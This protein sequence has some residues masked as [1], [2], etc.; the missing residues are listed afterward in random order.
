MA[1]AKATEQVDFIW[2]GKDKNGMRTKGEIAAKSETVA[3]SDL[4]QMGIRVISIKKKP[5]PLFGVKV[6]KITP[7]DIAIFSRQLATMLEAGVPLVQSFDIIGKGHENASMQHLLLSIKADIEGGS[8]LAE[9]LKKNPVYFDELFCNLVE[10]GEHAGVLET[11]LDKIATYKEKTES[12]KKKIKKALTYPIAVLVVAFVVTAILLIFVVPVFEEL[13]QGFGADLP[14]F[15]RMVIDLSEWMQ[16]WWWVIVA[17]VFGC[18]YTFGY[19]KKRSRKFNHALDRTLLKIPVVG[20]ILNKSAVARF[21]RTLSTMSAAGVPL[22]E[23]LES[24]AGSCGNIIYADAVLKMREEVSTGQR[25]QYAM[26][27]TALFPHMVVQMVAIGEESGSIDTMLTKVA[28]FFEEEVDNL[29]DNLSSLM[30]PII[31]SVLGVLVGGL[32]VAMYLPIFKM[33][34]AVG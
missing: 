20:L 27:Q 18:V 5:K 11:L 26:Q 3:R 31:M 13:F 6:Q 8:T 21:A 22:V 7:G 32:I 10:A 24:V 33:G 14:A 4:R 25:L 15:T 29:V 19:F 23:A 2:D 9:A 12:L 30:E 28:D 16:A 34:A 17:A 1:E